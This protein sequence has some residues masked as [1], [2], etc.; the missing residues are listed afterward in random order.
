MVQGARRLRFL[1]FLPVR[2]LFAHCQTLSQSESLKPP[3]ITKAAQ[4]A[5]FFS[6]TIM[7]SSSGESTEFNSIEECL[8]KHLPKDQLEEVTRILYGRKLR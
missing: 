4:T 7:S 6:A 1:V 2:I 5:L 8:E 3:T